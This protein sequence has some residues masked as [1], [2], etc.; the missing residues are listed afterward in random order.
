M[1]CCSSHLTWFWYMDHVMNL[2]KHIEEN[3]WESYA[4]ASTS[5]WPMQ[6]RTLAFRPHSPRVC[7]PPPP[8]LYRA[9]V[10]HSPAKLL[11]ATPARDYST[12]EDPAYQQRG[13]TSASEV[14]DK[15][16]EHPFYSFLYSNLTI[17]A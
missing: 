15:L 4:P 7:T 17:T 16:T 14:L 6:H 13:G 11:Q 8:P 1:D 10:H 3:L 9:S 5:V 12:V 2:Y